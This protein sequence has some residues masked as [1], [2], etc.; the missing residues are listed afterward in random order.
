VRRDQCQRVR[1][2]HKEAAAEDHVAVGV[3][4]G[5]RAEDGRVARIVGV[6]AHLSDE[7]CGV[8]EV[9]VGVATVEVLRRLAVDQAARFH[10]ELT[11]EERVRVRPGDAVHAVKG[12]AH[13]GPSEERAELR[14]VEDAADELEPVL[15]RVDHLHLKKGRPVRRRKHVPGGRGQVDVRQAGTDAVLAQLLRAR[16]DPIGE[17]LERR[18]AVGHV[19]LDPEV[20]VGPSRVVRRSEHDA[21]RRGTA[22]PLADDSRCGRRR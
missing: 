4:V 19:V 17:R 16:V 7:L 1:G 5:R 3:A 12:E 20:V 13:V 14:Q 21:A 10:A 15:R 2:S 11:A 18:A 9:G 6:E 8:D 22:L